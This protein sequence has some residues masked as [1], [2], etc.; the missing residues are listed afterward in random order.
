MRL[1]TDTSLPETLIVVPCFNES[2]RLNADAFVSFASSHREIG[3]VFVDDGS[4]DSTWSVLNSLCD[5]L[6]EQATCLRLNKNQGKGEAVRRGI[7]AAMQM[8]A[9]LVGYWDADLATP[10]SAIESMRRLATE[11]PE[12]VAVL[13]CRLP[14]MGRDIQRKPWRQFQSRIFAKAASRVL[15]TRVVDTQ[16]GAKL[17]RVSPLVR[18]LFGSPFLTRWI[19]DVEWL[20][21]L[22]ILVAPDR[23][24]SQVVYEM[25]LDR[26][27][28]VE[29]SKLTFRAA[30]KAATQLS[31]IAWRVRPGAW[32]HSDDSNRLMEV[33]QWRTQETTSRKVA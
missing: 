28:E 17:L 20:A 27:D 16:C 11:H 18:Q 4:S 2:K 3:F 30:V 29:G 26:W 15:K 8:G 5:E 7:Q 9:S 6:P 24:L 12:R 13:G 22:A 25:P 1:E 33:A 21:R 32:Q 19:F 14:L 31:T 10:L 23:K